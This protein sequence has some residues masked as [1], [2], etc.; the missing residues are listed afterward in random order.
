MYEKDFWKK[1]DMVGTEKLYML[2]LVHRENIRVKISSYVENKQ[3]VE[4]TTS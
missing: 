3:V 4:V 1:N 2:K